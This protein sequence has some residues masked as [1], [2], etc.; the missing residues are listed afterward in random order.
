L[1][2]YNDA[3]GVTAAF[4]KNLLARI[5]RELGGNFILD[6]FDHA[7]PFVEKQSRIEMYLISRCC[8]TVYIASLEQ[9]FHF[10]LGEYIHTEN[11]YKYTL[12]N[13]ATICHA[14]GFEIQER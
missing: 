11:S 5:N 1:S 8:Q 6:A 14:A 7:A 13:V 12:E 4:N 10:D 2:N 9:E 3:A